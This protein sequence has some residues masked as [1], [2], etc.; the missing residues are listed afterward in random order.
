[1]K[2]KDMDDANDEPNIKKSGLKKS[3][4]EVEHQRNDAMLCSRIV[5]MMHDENT[6]MP[7]LRKEI[8]ELY[9]C[10]VAD[11]NGMT[12]LHHAAKLG[13]S[14]LIMY[15]ITRNA[16]PQLKDGINRTPLMYAI[17]SGDLSSVEL[18]MKFEYDVHETDAINNS[19]FVLAYW[20]EMHELASRF[21]REGADDRGLLKG[22]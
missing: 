17:L 6:H 11:R 12:L 13:Y 9:D 8:R 16:N 3:K 2:K 19:L 22:N 10:N 20:M 18:L 5:Q 21:V 1:M 7:T 4:T 14:R 15:L